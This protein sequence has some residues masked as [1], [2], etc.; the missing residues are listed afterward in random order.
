MYKV[1]PGDPPV[2]LD[3]RE[4]AIYLGDEPDPS[5]PASRPPRPPRAEAISA[6]SLNIAQACN[7][8]CSYCYAGEGKFGSEA[9]LM[10]LEVALT[11][12]TRL[13]EERVAGSVSVGFIGGEPLL[14][15]PV[16]R[17]TVDFASKAA[18]RKRIPLTFG[19]T[20]NGTLLED[21]D[22]S[23]FRSHRFAVTI[24][25]DGAADVHNEVR[26]T[27]AGG[28]TFDRLMSRIRPL[29]A[30][31]GHSRVTARC[32]VTRRHLDV[33]STLDAL[34]TAGFSEAGISPLRTGPDPSIT[35]RHEDWPVLLDSMKRA[36]DR[37]WSRVRRDGQ[38]RFSNFAVALKQLHR[39]AVQAL[40]CRAGAS[41]VSVSAEGDYFTCHRTVGNSS[42]FLGSAATGPLAEGRRD[43]VM[44]RQVDSQ[45]PCR[46]CWA[47]YLC[48]GGCH[49]EVAE[50]GRSQ[51]D[52]IRGWLEFC[53]SRYPQVL[54]ERPDLFL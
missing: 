18:A 52:Y 25:I 8:T 40:P 12:V 23:L 2:L 44:A 31:P 7:L 21:S 39:G 32:T 15:R 29:L 16:L 9:R 45:E 17:A 46:W 3:I 13:L 5:L 54:S 20:T 30:D 11:A 38:F 35:L 36:A 27:R 34:L 48:G 33:E 10:P 53:I 24:S 14:N 4:S 28:A 6:I 19:I 49:A 22:V 41:Y 43:F 37:D 26:Q 42:F 50:A 1:I 47:R 51:C